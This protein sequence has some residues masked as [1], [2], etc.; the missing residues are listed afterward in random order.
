MVNHP[1]H[2]INMHEQSWCTFGETGIVPTGIYM[3][4]KQPDDIAL[5]MANYPVGKITMYEPS[6][7]TFIKK[8]EIGIMPTDIYTPINQSENFYNM[9]S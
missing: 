9:Q 1:G 5:T 4:I 3:P 8:G 2:K 6:W 7:C